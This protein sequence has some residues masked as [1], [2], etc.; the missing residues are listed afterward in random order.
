MK[1]YYLFGA[2]QNCIGVIKF[3][4]AEAIVAVIDSDEKKSGRE[5]EGIPIITLRQYI[6]QGS[7]GEIIIA[8]VIAGGEIAQMLE[9]KGIK[10][11]YK[12]PYMLMGFYENGRDIVDKLELDRF[13]EIV[14]CT[15]NPISELIEEE[16][17]KKN[18]SIRFRYIDRDG[19]SEA[20]IKLPILVTNEDD[21]CILQGANRADDLENLIDINGIYREKYSFVN[22]DIARFKNIHKGGRCFII[23]NGPSLRYEDLEKLRKENEICFGCNRIYLAYPDTEW[24]PDYYV[25]VDY[26]II[27]KDRARILELGGT[28]FIRHSY[29]QTEDWTKYGI[30]EFRGIAGPLHEPRISFDMMEGVY[31]GNTVVYDALQIALYMGFQEIYLLGVDMTAGIRYED[32]GSHFYKSPDTKENLGTSNS[33][34]TRRNLGYAAR[35]MAE[36]GRILRNATRGGELDEVPRV[37]FDSLF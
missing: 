9:E 2:G 12:C 20:D 16:A 30:Y 6:R 26:I 25:A 29:C 36:S 21:K 11:Y 35:K 15:R 13:Q 37:D 4:G 31:T 18:G 8:N 14:C 34:E 7:N 3:F 28:R 19:L 1:R 5:L 23:G 10:N 22:R 32:E 24:R 17:K 33:L 27:R